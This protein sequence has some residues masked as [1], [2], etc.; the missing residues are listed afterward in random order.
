LVTNL[1]K[2]EKL[3]LW[4][5]SACCEVMVWEKQHTTV[6]VREEEASTLV[7]GPET[8]VALVLGDGRRRALPSCSAR[9]VKSNAHAA[10]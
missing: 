7:A 1:E 2:K 10:D 3:T 9:S 5:S 8:T 4:R 6:Q